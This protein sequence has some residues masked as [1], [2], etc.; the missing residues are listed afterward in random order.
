MP[1][2]GAAAPQTPAGPAT[3]AVEKTAAA[4]TAAGRIYSGQASSARTSERRGRLLA[5]GLELFGT[6]GFA[7]TKIK[8]VCQQAGLSERYFYE[9]FTSREQLLTEVYDGLR[10]RLMADVV[11]AMRNPASTPR[12]AIHAGVA[13]VA[14]FMLN[15]PRH[16]QIILVEIVGV[17]PDLEAKR[18]GSLQAFAAESMRQ[19][20]RLAG[21]DPE[22]MQ[23][24]LGSNPQCQPLLQ[25][26]EFARLTAVSSVGGLNNMLLDALLGGTTGNTGPII[27]VAFE[28]MCNAAT[29]IRTRANPAM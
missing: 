17:T 8:D 19:L 10:R 11:A 20:L 18:H 13:A 29:G 14:T 22:E 26:M 23:Q 27:E 4:R 2:S 21:I 3:S 15:D 25:A 12:E 1:P 24:L 9:S 6:R 28:L 16:A 5:A 7:H